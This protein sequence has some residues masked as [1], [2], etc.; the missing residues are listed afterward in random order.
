MLGPSSILH[1]TLPACLGLVHAA[2]ELTEVEQLL[3]LS[4]ASAKERVCLRLSGALSAV[5]HAR[6]SECRLTIIR[7]GALRMESS[8]VLGDLF[9]I[10][11]S[12]LMDGSAGRDGSTAWMLLNARGHGTS[13]SIQLVSRPLGARLLRA[14]PSVYSA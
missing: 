11:D 4:A 12:L 13:G 5:D 10:D 14:F 3:D 7:Y 1:V 6:M 9:E 8:V 2:N